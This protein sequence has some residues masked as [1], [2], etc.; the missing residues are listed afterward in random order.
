MAKNL[1]KI[2]SA[3]TI[4]TLVCS[5][6][7]LAQQVIESSMKQVLPHGKTATRPP[8]GWIA[9]AGAEF[10]EAAVREIADAL[11]SSGLA[12]AG[13]VYVSI[14]DSWQGERDASGNLRSGSRFP[15]IAKLAAYL[16]DKGLKLSLPASPGSTTCANTPG[17]FGHE[18]Q[19][20]KI[21]ASWG[22]D[23]LIYDWCGAEAD[24]GRPG[25]PA[26]YQKMAK[27]LAAAGRPI[28]FGA[29]RLSPLLSDWPALSGLNFW[30]VERLPPSWRA[31]EAAGFDAGPPAMNG[32]G[33]GRW[34]YPGE[35]HVGNDNLSPAEQRSQMA[36][37]SLLPA[38]LFFSA[39]PRKLTP[40]ALAIL[41]NPDV[42]A[43]NQDEADRP[44]WR[45]TKWMDKDVWARQLASGE[46]VLGLFN[47]G[48]SVLDIRVKWKD[49]D[50]SGSFQ[51][52]ELWSGKDRG[53][54]SERFTTKVEPHDVALILIKR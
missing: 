8:M 40:D 19:D 31:V 26:A 29:A 28:L 37:W 6:G 43:V 10:D 23:Q 30:N 12:A 36:L 27:A 24:Y 44:G 49:L 51:V 18:E 34:Y 38:P 50:Q 54:W 4:L 9:P 17:S 11:V 25:M 47:R 39:D 53:R 21:F 52:R 2:L 7:T 14:P 22:I 16:H 45:V 46:Y 5:S 48:D 15:D 1:V 3:G 41:R 20:A 35:L 33:A 13:Y 42:I 32:R